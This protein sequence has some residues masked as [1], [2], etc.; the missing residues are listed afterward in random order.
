MG[1]F[2]TISATNLG[3]N[4]PWMLVKSFKNSKSW[5]IPYTHFCLVDLLV[6]WLFVPRT[7]N[8]FLGLN[9]W[10][11]TFVALALAYQKSICSHK[12]STGKISPYSNLS[13]L[14]LK[15]GDRLFKN[16]SLNHISKGLYFCTSPRSLVVFF[17][18]SAASHWLENKWGVILPLGNT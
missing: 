4:L 1:C 12:D 3:C 10:G 13:C 18:L 16:R 14:S 8:C 9:Q 7:L 15:P 2:S 5:W 11:K 6:W 17:S